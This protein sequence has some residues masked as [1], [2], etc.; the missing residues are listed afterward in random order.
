MQTKRIY[1]AYVHNQDGAGQSAGSD[2]NLKNLRYFVRQHFG[3][4][5]KVIID[6]IEIDGDGHSTFAPVTV[7]EYTLRN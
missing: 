7:A 3:R 2:T 5:W 6:M 1:R 4:G